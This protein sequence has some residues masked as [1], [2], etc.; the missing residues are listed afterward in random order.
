MFKIIL[1]QCFHKR[2]FFFQIIDDEEL[3]DPVHA[4]KR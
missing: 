3:E 4:S 1:R 2:F